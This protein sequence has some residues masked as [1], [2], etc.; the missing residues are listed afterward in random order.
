MAAVSAALTGARSVQPIPTSAPG[1]VAVLGEG[2]NGTQLV[3]INAG[4]TSYSLDVRTQGWT[5][6]TARSVTASPFSKIAGGGEVTRTE[7]VAEA[8]GLSFRLL[9]WSI[10]TITRAR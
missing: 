6:A 2:P 3:V 9:P 7:L 1:A 8:G 5:G 10:T 4:A